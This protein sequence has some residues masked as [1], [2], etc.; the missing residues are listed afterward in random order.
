MLFGIG[1]LKNDIWA[2][3]IKTMAFFTKLPWDVNLSILVIGI[4]EIFTGVALIIG[5]FT[6][7]FA[8]LASAQ[9]LG[10][11]ILLKCEEV[12]DIGLLGAVIYMSIVKN[13]A[14]GVD[15]LLAR[16]KEKL[17]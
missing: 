2:E 11:L 8:L 3:T 15:Y 12:R 14:F 16:Q 7:F 5:L 1:K 6:R 9:L 13:N 10:I 17:K 4:F